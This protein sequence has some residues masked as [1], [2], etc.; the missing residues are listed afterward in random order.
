M[1]TGLGL[2]MARQIV[3]MHGGRIWFESKAGVGS[4]FYFSVPMQ[5]NPA[6]PRQKRAE[7]IPVASR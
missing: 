5:T 1:G 4:E 7:A 6:G 2:P 3:E